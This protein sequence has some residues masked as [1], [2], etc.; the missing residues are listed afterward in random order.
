MKCECGME[1]KVGDETCPRCGA[2]QT[3]CTRTEAAAR[4]LDSHDMLEEAEKLRGIADQCECGDC[5]SEE[6]E[7]E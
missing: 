4:V 1:I 7:D 3:V 6:L 2:P 5:R